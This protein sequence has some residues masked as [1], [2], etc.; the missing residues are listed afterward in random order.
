MISILVSLIVVIIVLGLVY[1]LLTLLPIPQPFHNIIIV[2]FV[3]IAILV[4]VGDLLPI[5][6]IGHLPWR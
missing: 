6:G 4:V 5:G 3:L 1:W 2:L